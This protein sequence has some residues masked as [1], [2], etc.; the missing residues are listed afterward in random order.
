[1]NRMNR[2]DEENRFSECTPDSV[3][4]V[5]PVGIVFSA[6]SALQSVR[7]AHF[8]EEF[9]TDGTDFTDVRREGSGPAFTCCE[10]L[11]REIR[12]IRGPIPLVADGRAG[13]LREKILA[14]MTDFGRRAGNRNTKTLQ[15][16]TER[17]E[18][19]PLRCPRCLLLSNPP[20][21]SEGSCFAGPSSF[22]EATADRTADRSDGRTV[23][24]DPNTIPGL[25]LSAIQS[26]LLLSD[27]HVHGR[28]PLDTAGWMRQSR[29]NR[30]FDE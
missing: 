20:W 2:I 4:P 9:T 28:L 1:M 27:G 14:K 21:F 3:N 25:P 23:G 15:E 5:N 17:T 29:S 6:P 12:E 22:A 13:P 11:I 8:R 24:P 26:I 10:C 16:Q 30:M 7:V 19:N 18:K